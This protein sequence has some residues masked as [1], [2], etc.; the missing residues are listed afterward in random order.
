[1][2]AW[3]TYDFSTLLLLLMLLCACWKDIRSHRVPNRLVLAGIVGGV[4]LHLWFLGWPGIAASLAGLLLGGL[5][6]LPFY[7]LK[8]NRQRL[9]SAG[10]V[11]LMAAVGAF[12]GP[13]N[14]LLAAGLTLAAGTLAGLIWLMW[15]GALGR[16]L[17]RNWLT[18]KTLLLTGQWL[19]QSPERDDIA[20][21]R[22]P[23]A[24]AITAG[25]L[26]ALGHLSLL[27]FYH[28][29]TLLSGVLS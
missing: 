8:V 17:Q 10:D 25:T 3:N 22:F 24:L 26:L 29:R 18:L 20:M 12:L 6:L 11:K 27:Q 15:Q 13:L 1:M 5:I 23:Y 4:S 9:M 19:Y 14:I 16:Y 2:L 21:Q 7:L 28:L